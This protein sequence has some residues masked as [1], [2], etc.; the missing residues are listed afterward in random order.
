MAMGAAILA[1]PMKG[2]GASLIGSFF[3]GFTLAS[4]VALFRKRQGSIFQTCDA[5]S[6]G[7][8]LVPWIWSYSRAARSG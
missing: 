6:S 4:A 2:L 3:S 7:V 1:M 8:L 5:V